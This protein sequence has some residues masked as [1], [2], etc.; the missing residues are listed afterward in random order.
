LD[1][2]AEPRI[3]YNDDELRAA[4]EQQSLDTRSIGISNIRLNPGGS[5]L[6]PSPFTL[7]A[8]DFWINRGAVVDYTTVGATGGATA[9][10]AYASATAELLEKGTGATTRS[11]S[12]LAELTYFVEIGVGPPIDTDIGPI[13]DLGFV[14]IEVV[15]HA[16][17][18]TDLLQPVE[19]G[20]GT[21]TLTLRN[22][23]TDRILIDYSTDDDPVV[24]KTA[25]DTLPNRFAFDTDI[26]VFD[27]LEVNLK[28]EAFAVVDNSIDPDAILSSS[29][30]VYVDPYF[31]FDEEAYDALRAADPSLPDVEL[32]DVFTF[33]VSANI[34]QEPSV[35]PLPASW[36]MFS[37]AAGLL[38][39]R[40]RIGGRSS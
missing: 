7:Q 17:R 22:R 21:G 32:A 1:P 28:A 19:Y 30:E 13:F 6:I 15:S 33:L 12:A 14:P 40:K 35:V 37:V 27:V 29:A 38:G 34:Y 4:Q 10:W 23:T 20:F 11:V 2:F 3:N 25:G 24:G 9:P 5:M 8:T 16:F 26:S 31:L 36:L 18:N 39:L